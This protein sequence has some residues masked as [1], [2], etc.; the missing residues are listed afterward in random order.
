MRSA[1]G[2]AQSYQAC[3]SR[4][5][6]RWL[7]RVRERRR[8]DTRHLDGARVRDLQVRRGPA[9]ARG[10]RHHVRVGIRAAIIPH[11]D[12]N[13]G[14]TH[15]TRFCYLGERR[16]SIMEKDLPEGAFVLGVDEHTACTFDIEAGTASVEGR[17]VVT[18]RA[19]GRSAT[20]PSGEV[21]PIARILETAEELARGART[22]TGASSRSASCRDRRRPVVGCHGAAKHI[23]S[24]RSRTGA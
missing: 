14:G 9:L 7:R 20:L 22:E 13:E 4:N 1:S 2:K 23:A 18:V 10:P 24:R 11:Y 16:L 12:N 5:S 21:F 6:T 3:S 15:D 8:P 17:G 19:A